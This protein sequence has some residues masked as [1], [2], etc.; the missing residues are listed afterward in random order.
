VSCSRNQGGGGYGRQEREMFPA[1]CA[2]CW[3]DTMVPFQ[4]SGE[5][6]VYCRECFVLQHVATGKSLI[7]ETFLGLMS[8]GGFLFVIEW[9]LLDIW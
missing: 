8:L 5:K 3:K 1:V 2:T 9:V 4:P 6:P 7:V